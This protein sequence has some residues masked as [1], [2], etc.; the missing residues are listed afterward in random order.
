MPG[1]PEKIGLT[2]EQRVFAA[3]ARKLATRFAL[4]L[5]NRPPERGYFLR[6]TAEGL[7]LCQADP[8]GPGPIRVEFAEGTMGHRLRFGG[9]RGQAL[10]RAVGI[11]PGFSPSVWDATA[12]LGRDGFVLAS[13]GCQVT[14]CE[15]SAVLAAMLRD[16][17]QRAALHSELSDWL[18]QRIQLIHAD[19]RQ[20]LT[21][22][23]AGER[24][25]VVYLDPMYPAGKEHV[26][27]KK[28]M[29]A[30]QHIL[31]P[32]QD[33]HELLEVALNRAKRRVVV[34]RPSRAGWLN[35]L[36]PHTSIES[37]KTRYD[38]YVTLT[39]DKPEK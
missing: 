9:G 1:E 7:A 3:D 23:D 8:G 21:G 18:E 30:L 22:L 14:L 26:L 35:D 17:L 39:T 6:L 37:K 28:E 38:V 32:D 12:G 27:V 20:A 36:K 2:I 25:D 29:R 19:A 4:N 34:K 13:L 33:S 31:G 11:K 15:R 24:P 10:A 5:L 16:G